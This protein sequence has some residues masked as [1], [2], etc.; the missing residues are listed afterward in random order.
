MIPNMTTYLLTWN[1]ANWAWDDF[2]AFASAV[3]KN[4]ASIERWS[5]GNTRRVARG[6]RFFLLKQGEGDRGIIGAGTA[7]SDVFDAPHFLDDR[8]SKGDTALY[9]TCAFDT[10][11]RLTREVIL[12]IEELQD[13]IPEVHWAP[14]A[15]GI[16]VPT[17]AAEKLE[18]MWHAHIQRVRASR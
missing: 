10:L 6:D 18:D 4:G 14:L 13:K 1:P 9:V 11:L 16:S 15:S 8:R 7:V 5:T 17:T 3:R 12:P 2:D